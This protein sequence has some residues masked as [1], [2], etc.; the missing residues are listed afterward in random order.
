MVG[1]M[2]RASFGCRPGFLLCDWHKLGAQEGPAERLDARGG[3]T[4]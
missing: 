1:K 3:M 4:K 2:R